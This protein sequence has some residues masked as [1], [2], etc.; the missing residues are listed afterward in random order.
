[1]LESNGHFAEIRLRASIRIGEISRELEKAEAHGGKICL[2]NGRKSKSETLK[3]AGIP[4]STA[5]D[6]EQLIVAEGCG[7]RPVF[8]ALVVFVLKAHDIG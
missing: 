8:L 3:A 6:Y 1:V 7:R 4:V 5:N 2:P